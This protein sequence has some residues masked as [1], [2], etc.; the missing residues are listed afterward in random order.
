MK[1]KVQE[2]SNPFKFGT[3]EKKLLVV[4]CY[5]VILATVALTAFTLSTRN[6]SSIIKGIQKYFL[7]E[8]GGHN[9]S[10][11]C[12]RDFERHS[13][14]SV[15]TLAYVLLGLFPAVNLIYAV[16]M[17]E[18]KEMAQKLRVKRKNAYSSSDTP[19]TGSTVAIIST[20]KRKP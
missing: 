13:N 18:L 17:K 9:S 12:S 10:S 3:A 5:Y 1:L 6:S 4:F 11:P 2:T 16:N 19:S 14:P 8:Q 7:C 20:L 15:T